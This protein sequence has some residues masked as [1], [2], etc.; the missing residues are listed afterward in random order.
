[1]KNNLCFSFYFA[2]LG[3]YTLVKIK[4]VIKYVRRMYSYLQPNL[5]N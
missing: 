5:L 3:C 4:G 2:V 1:M